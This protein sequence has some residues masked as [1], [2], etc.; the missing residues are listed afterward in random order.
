MAPPLLP[1]TFGPAHRTLAGTPGPLTTLAQRSATESVRDA[2]ETA[3]TLG[4][5]SAHPGS[6]GTRD[7]WEALATVAADDLGAARAI[8]PH[9]DALAILDQAG[10]ETHDSRTWG[11]FAAEG[12]ADPLV[13]TRHDETWTVSGTKPWCS[14]A[15]RLD[16]ALVTA[17]VGEGDR[18]LFSVELR[19]PGVDALEDAWHARGLAEIPSGPVH[20]DGIR[21]T[22]VGDAGWYLQRPGFAW[23]GIGVAACWYGGAIGIA[24]TLF[25]SARRA[26]PSPF[27]LMHLGAI[28]ASLQD[29][30]RALLEAS[31]LI[32]DGAATGTEGKRL[33]KRVRS[34]VARTCESVIVR[35]GH[36]LGPAPLALDDAHAKRVVD[37]Q[38]YLRQHHAERDDASLGETIAR[39]EDA[40]W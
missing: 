29:S 28:D 26:D 35:A 18:R 21:A 33:A 30:R 7:L 1:V 27:L 11:V 15:G 36:A 25:E 16:A 40:P 31:V 32:D 20:F 17:S 34:T 9:L 12:G 39:D 8:E 2:L 38:L 13:A 14:L 4:A 5:R 3:R 6:G 24:R 22:P 10:I 37:L 23:G 19:Q